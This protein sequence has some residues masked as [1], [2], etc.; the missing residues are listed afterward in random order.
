MSELTILA[1][2]DNEAQNY[3]LTRRLQSAGFKVV[4]AYTAE[5]TM[6][7]AQEMPDLIILDVNLPD[8]NGFEVCRRLKADPQLARIPVVFLSATSQDVAATEMG[9]SVGAAAFL[10]APV[11]QA[12]LVSVIRGT[13][14]RR[15][16]SA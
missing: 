1:V 16:T 4:T 9:R 11:E 5:E 12:H 3:A 7:R 10:F 13:L 15:G 14:A 2:D 6:A 8:L